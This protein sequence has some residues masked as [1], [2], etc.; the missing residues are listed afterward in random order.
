MFLEIDYSKIL[1]NSVA[2]HLENICNLLFPPLKLI[3]LFVA[4]G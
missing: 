1:L 2:M 3:N 4:S